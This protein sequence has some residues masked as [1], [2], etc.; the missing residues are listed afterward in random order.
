MSPTPHSNSPPQNTASTTRRGFLN[1]TA[2]ASASALLATSGLAGCLG[3]APDKA[4]AAARVDLPESVSDRSFSRDLVDADFALSYAWTFG[5]DWQVDLTIPRA[6]YEAAKAAPRSLAKVFDEAKRSR[7]SR[8]LATDLT[9][10]LD[11]LGV[12]D[13]IDRIRVVASFVRSLQYATDEEGTGKK[14]Y[15]RYV[16][17]TLVENT[18]DCEDFAAILAGIFAS[19]EFDADPR[20]V[21]LPGHTGIALDVASLDLEGYT[22]TTK[23]AT[24]NADDADE[25]DRDNR[26]LEVLDIDGREYLYIDPT[27]P[28]RPGVVP[29]EYREYDVVATYDGHWH[30]HDFDALLE[31]LKQSVDQ[32]IADPTKY[33]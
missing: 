20:L 4:G 2:V 8:Q 13:P 25:T 26:V 5:P 11:D 24:N 23:P 30:L 10:A 9:N 15:P 17:E 6:R 12:N 14:E 19:P 16:A 28:V 27:W 7:I 18:G 29:E 22:T 32:G 33:V 21:I 3:S 31:H 1:K